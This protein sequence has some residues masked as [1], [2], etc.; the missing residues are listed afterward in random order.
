MILREILQRIQSAYSKGV[1]SDDSRLS[2]RHIYNKLLS[3]RAL[4]LSREAKAKR[5]ISSWNYMTIPCAEI[6]EVPSNEECP[7]IP[8]TGCS[9]Y[10]TKHKL[11]KPIMSLVGHMIKSVTNLNNTIKYTEMSL[12]QSIYSKG[13]KYAKNSNK[14]ILENGYLYI[15]SKFPPL[16]VKITMLPEDVA[17][18]HVFK[19]FCEGNNNDDCGTSILDMEFPID[20]S[21]VDP[22]IHFT[23][24]EL[25]IGLARSQ[26]DM[27]NN[28]QDNAVSGFKP[29]QQ[30]PQENNN[31]QQ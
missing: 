19:S 18:A 8:E 5:K 22:L 20:S 7:C 1:S 15:V 29:Q 2:N 4:L 27:I 25:V 28:S 21:L 16:I 14:Y 12:N 10:R 11:P 30:Q 13:S 24:E 31:E 23:Y 3:V 26:E 9:V 17:E 6:I